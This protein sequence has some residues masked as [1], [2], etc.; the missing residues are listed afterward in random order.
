MIYDNHQ[1]SIAYITK[2]F[3]GD[4]DVL[5]LLISGSIAHGFNTE[6]SDVDINIVVGNDYFE[7]KKKAKALTYGESAENFYTGGYYDGKYITL[8]FLNS[9][10]EHGN[11]PSRFALHDSLI[12]FDKTGRVKEIMERIARYPSERVH[13]SAL[14]FLSQFEGWKWYCGEALRK[15]DA[16]L[17]DV[18]V[19][20]LILFGGRLILLHNK[21]FFPYHKW[22]LKVLE[23]AP[24]KPDGLIA[25][26]QVLMKERSK[27]NIDIFYNIIMNYYD[28]A[29]GQ[30][31]SWSSYFVSD[32]EH[33]WLTGHEY[34]ENI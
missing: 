13:E 25:C 4:P 14:R 2:K 30:E 18:S 17:L 3:S 29:E 23:R 24:E 32:I 15:E 20:K 7:T 10:A 9:V 8:D 27:E 31:Y 34:I 26:I 22:F 16:Y 19:L 1:K 5:A 28:W 33:N 6:K 21:L 11:E 12:A